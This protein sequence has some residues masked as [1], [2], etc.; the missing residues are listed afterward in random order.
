MERAKG[1]DPP[2]T[3]RRSL[4]CGEAKEM[5]AAGMAIG[6]HTHPHA[7]LSQLSRDEQRRE[8]TLSRELL[9]QNL[10]ISADVL[11]YP[12]GKT[13]SF[14]NQ[15]QELARAAGYRAA[16][17]FYGGVN[18]NGKIAPYDVR[19]IGIAGQSSTRFRVDAAVCKATGRYWP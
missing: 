2:Q 17:S 3:L 18:L 4:N 19:R 10:G 7:V 12:V 9:N 15:S 13:S 11:A 8:L 1:D 16:F 5:I 6:S 14:S